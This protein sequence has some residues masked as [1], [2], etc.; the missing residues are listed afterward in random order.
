MASRSVSKHMTTSPSRINAVRP[1]SLYNEIRQYL[2][3]DFVIPIDILLL[4]IGCRRPPGSNDFSSM[5]TAGRLCIWLANDAGH[6]TAV[7]SDKWNYRIQQVN[8][9]DAP[10]LASSGGPAAHA[11]AAV[12]LAR[13]PQPSS[14]SARSCWSR[15]VVG[16]LCVASGGLAGQRANQ[17]GPLPTASRRSAKL[18]CRAVR[19]SSSRHAVFRNAMPGTAPR[20]HP[21]VRTWN[22]TLQRCPGNA[23]SCMPLRAGEASITGSMHFC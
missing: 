10:R 14:G 6:A 3:E 9:A 22:G 18:R 17:G 19:T 21:G 2:H 8:G 13:I 5:S 12:D 23:L 11:E 16:E 20:R 1:A 15:L 4:V 7:R